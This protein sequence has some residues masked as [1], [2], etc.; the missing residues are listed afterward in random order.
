MLRARSKSED[1]QGARYFSSCRDSSVADMTTIFRSGR[2][3]LLQLQRARER[4][5]AVEMALVKFVEKDRRHV[6]QF[7]ILDQ[8]PQQNSFRDETNAGPRS[9]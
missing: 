3:R 6:A 5:V 8:L 9:R 2:A 7:R 4:D 1:G